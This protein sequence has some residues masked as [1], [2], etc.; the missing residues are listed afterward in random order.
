MS[1]W[2]E[3]PCATPVLGAEGR[4]EC[5]LLLIAGL[6]LRCGCLQCIVALVGSVLTNLAPRPVWLLAGLQPVFP[7]DGPCGW[8]HAFECPGSS[9]IAGRP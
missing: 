6:A 8:E 7:Q 5:G 3:S 9:K 2:A 4:T 1:S